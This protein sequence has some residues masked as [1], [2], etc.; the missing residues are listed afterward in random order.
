MTGTKPQRPGPFGPR[1]V[2][3]VGTG[4]EFPSLREAAEAA[5]VGV[6]E[7][8]EVCGFAGKALAGSQW[9]YI[10]EDGEVEPARDERLLDCGRPVVCLD[11]GRTWLSAKAAAGETGADKT[12]I[13]KAC[14]GKQATS[15]GLSWAFLEDIERLGGRG[16]ARGPKPPPSRPV[17]READGEPFPSIAAAGRAVGVDPAAVR[18]ACR[19]PG[20]TCAGSTWRY[21]DGPQGADRPPCSDGS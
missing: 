11:D 16:R 21:A 3:R 8:H 1:R 18:R 9:R 19:K 12:G 2:A 6:I 15:G 20:A 7:L 10:G 13:G 5:G 4:E 17:I 14:K